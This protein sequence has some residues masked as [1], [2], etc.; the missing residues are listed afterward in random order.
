MSS[1]DDARAQEDLSGFVAGSDVESSVP[2]S[3]DLMVNPIMDVEQED[4]AIM[5]NEDEDE[6]EDR[7]ESE[8]TLS[9]EDVSHS[10]EQE[11]DEDDEDD[12]PDLSLPTHASFVSS[13]PTLSTEYDVDDTDQS[14][15]TPAPAKASKNKGKGKVVEDS[16]DELSLIVSPAKQG[17]KKK[18]PKETPGVTSIR[19]MLQ[20]ASL[21][22]PSKRVTRS[23][24]QK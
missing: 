20:E 3:P 24:V 10:I 16:E 5:T 17:A 22:A 6:D 23:R 11:D 13:S 15:V 2:G 14:L 19:E 4:E 18:A 21:E 1:P 12:E 8:S 9:G 7:N